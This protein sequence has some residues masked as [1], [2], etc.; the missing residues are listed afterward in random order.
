MKHFPLP[1]FLLQL[2]LK[3]QLVLRHVLLPL[4]HDLVQSIACIYQ[5]IHTVE[6]IINRTL[7]SSK[8]QSRWCFGTTTWHHSVPLLS[9]VAEKIKNGFFP[10]S[11]K[12]ND[13]CT[14]EN[15][16]YTL[17]TWSAGWHIIFFWKNHQRWRTL[18][19]CTPKSTLIWVKLPHITRDN[20][21]KHMLLYTVLYTIALC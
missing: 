14:H 6:V 16:W 9:V 2:I 15:L 20:F 21:V 8:P 17:R 3:L 18:F 4:F 11:M 5:C 12:N 1:Q 10:A 13:A 19:T 7:V